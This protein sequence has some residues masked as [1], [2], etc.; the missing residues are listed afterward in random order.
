MNCPGMPDEVLVAW[1]DGELPAAESAR[2]AEHVARCTACGREAALL[3]ESGDLI[4][5]MERREAT[6]G[7]E[8]RVL[9]AARAPAP[10]GRL[11]SLRGWRAAA[12]AAVLLAA[13]AG[14]A[15]LARPRETASEPGALTARE[16][17]A[18]AEDLFVI[19]NLDAL[20]EADVAELAQIV[21]DLDVID[22]AYAAEADGG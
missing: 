15:W 8:A 16:E 17:Q 11:A 5:R 7:F 10:R 9:A 19:S 14:A 3:R 18:L 2:A 6:A 4:A 13:A 1:L 20:Q 22:A 12:A 21:D